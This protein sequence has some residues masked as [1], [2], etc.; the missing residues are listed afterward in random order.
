[1][2]VRARRPASRPEWPPLGRF[3]ARGDSG[4]G[5]PPRSADG[6]REV[7]SHDALD[8]RAWRVFR[9]GF[10]DCPADGS[11]DGERRASESGCFAYISSG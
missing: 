2:G 1:M 6:R 7:T 10:K 11:R 9:L 5:V 3:P 8:D 4:P